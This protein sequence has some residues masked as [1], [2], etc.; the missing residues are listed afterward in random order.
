MSSAFDGTAMSNC[1]KKNIANS[2]GSQISHFTYSEWRHLNCTIPC[3]FD[4]SNFSTFMDEYLNGGV[5]SFSCSSSIED[6]D[7]SRV[8]NFEEIFQGHTTF[9]DDISRW[10]TANAMNFKHLFYSASVFDQDLSKWNVERVKNFDLTFRSATNFRGRGLE[11]WNTVSATSMYDTFAYSSSFQGDSIINWRTE[12]VKNM[13]H[14]FRHAEGFN[15]DLSSWNVTHVTDFYDMFLNTLDLT[16]CNKRQIGLSWTSQSQVFTQY[17]SWATLHNDCAVET[18]CTIITNQELRDYVDQWIT[19][20]TNHPCGEVIGDWNVS[21]VTDFSYVFCGASTS[22]V[23]ECNPLRQ[24]FNTN[25]SNWD[26]SSVT[27]LTGTF[28]HATSFTGDGV[29]NWDT[30]RVRIMIRTFMG[31]TSFTGDGVSNW[32]TTSVILLIETFR[33]ST[34]F[35]ANLSNWN[36]A[37]VIGLTQTFQ[38]STLFT[39]EGVENWDTSKIQILTYGTL[40]LSYTKH[41]QRIIT[42]H[43]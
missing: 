22:D 32:D 39:G 23:P 10:N 5:S 37:K 36:T 15:A 7:V 4:D 18:S 42:T 28:Y 17:S 35:N 40:T 9:N 2:W 41:G 13:Q 31:A 25:I 19:D 12:N 34:S 6:F 26:T 30:S 14:M 20:S 8:T 33:G 1:N 3:V 11:N 24:N 29:A 43:T 27:D 21:N 38:D 16:N